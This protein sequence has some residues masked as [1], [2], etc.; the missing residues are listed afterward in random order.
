M[1]GVITATVILSVIVHGITASPWARRYGDWTHQT[2]PK[3][4]TQ[5]AAEPLPARRSQRPHASP[6][7]HR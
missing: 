3:I 1:L 7:A 2:K 5:H 4:E 6:N